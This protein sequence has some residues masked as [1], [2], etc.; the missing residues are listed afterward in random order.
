MVARHRILSDY[1]QQRVNCT[2]SFSGLVVAKIVARTTYVRY[3]SF[4]LITQRS[5][6]S[7]DDDV[8]TRSYLSIRCVPLN[9]AAQECPYNCYS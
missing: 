3:H 2:S 6:C 5:S 8:A 9:H 1:H 7:D 4:V